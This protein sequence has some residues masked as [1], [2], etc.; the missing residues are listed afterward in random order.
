MAISK[1]KDVGAQV[2]AKSRELI[3]EFFQH[4]EEFIEA[5]PGKEDRNAIFQ[6]WAIQKIAGLQLAVLELMKKLD[7]IE[8]SRD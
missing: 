5:N 1:N 4:Q 3:Q 2:D 8:A 6:G 7:E